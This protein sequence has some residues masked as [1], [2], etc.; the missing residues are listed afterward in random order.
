MLFL[1]VTLLQICC[2]VYQWNNFDSQCAGGEGWYATDHLSPFSCVLCCQLNFPSDLLTT[3]Y[4]HFFLQV[5]S[6]GWAK[7]ADCFWDQI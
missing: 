4:S 5:F 7:K 6:T 2:W 1:M 3:C